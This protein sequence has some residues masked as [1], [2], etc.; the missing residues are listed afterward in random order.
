MEAG[1]IELDVLGDAVVVSRDFVSSL[2]AA[3][4]GKAGVSSRHRDLSLVLR[5]ALAA[6]RASLDGGETRALRA[7]LEEEGLALPE[8]DGAG[9]GA[10][11]GRD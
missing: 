2:A 6:G 3:A 1:V 7:V 9:R 4:A 11:A 5:R 8:Q 10:D